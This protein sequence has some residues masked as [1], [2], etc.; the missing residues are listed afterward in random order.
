MGRVLEPEPGATSQKNSLG[1]GT[2]GFLHQVLARSL[3]S[4]LPNSLGSPDHHLPQLFQQWPTDNENRLRMAP[5]CASSS[6]L[7]G[8]VTVW[9]ATCCVT[10]PSGTWPGRPPLH[11][12][13][14]HLN[15]GTDCHTCSMSDCIRTESCYPRPNVMV[16]MDY[17]VV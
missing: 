5:A 1:K 4:A 11:S 14:Q 6:L 16:H 15:T 12:Q 7:P 10:Q 3:S 9:A 13:G 17:C 8:G 2:L